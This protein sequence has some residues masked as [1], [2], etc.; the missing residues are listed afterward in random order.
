MWYGCH[1]QTSGNQT[2]I[3]CCFHWLSHP[4]HDLLYFSIMDSENTIPESN[5]VHIVNSAPNSCKR[6][7]TVTRRAVSIHLVIRERSNCRYRLQKL[8]GSV[9]DST[10]CLSQYSYSLCLTIHTHT[11]CSALAE[12]DGTHINCVRALRK[13]SCEENYFVANK[14]SSFFYSWSLHIK[15]FILHISCC[16]CL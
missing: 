8:M 4:F 10:E 12:I 11:L 14:S 16:F 7:S 9:I 5:P 1:K 6:S 2:F 3:Y 15:T 13:P